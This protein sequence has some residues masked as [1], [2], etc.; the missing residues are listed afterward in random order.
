MLAEYFG[1]SVAV[2]LW[3]AASAGV[4]NFN[5]WILAASRFPYAKGMVAMHMLASAVLSWALYGVAGSRLFPSMPRVWEHRGKV[6]RDVLVISA[7]G[8]LSIVLSNEA[9]K[10]CSVPFVQMCK[11][12]NAVLAYCVALALGQE[13]WSRPR[14][15]LLLCVFL[16]CCV[17]IHGELTFSRFGFAIQ[18]THQLCE[19]WKIN[20]QAALFRSSLVKL[21]AL[22]LVLLLT[23]LCLCW[24]M[25]LLLVEAIALRREHGD[26]QTREILQHGLALWPTLFLNCLSAYGL[27]VTSSIV[28][29]RVNAVGF[30]L[31][32]AVKNIVI[33]VVATVLMGEFLT[34]QQALGY[35]FALCSVVL[36]SLVKLFPSRFEKGLGRGVVALATEARRYCRRAPPIRIEALECL[37]KEV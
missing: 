13:V 34:L 16:G 23:P 8:T 19:V 21:D 32:G 2:V 25:A 11:E 5:K 36:Y 6:F 22:S 29:S 26:S 1:A 24:T 17:A 37:G 30:C 27:N 20:L 9:Y 28:V 33:L 15:T 12:G 18:A 31:A 10:H 7:L 35:A 4:V 14:A 3:V